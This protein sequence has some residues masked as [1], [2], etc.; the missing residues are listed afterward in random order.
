MVEL[1][2]DITKIDG[3]IG[4]IKYI[5]SLTLFGESLVVILTI[6]TFSIFRSRYDFSQSAMASLFIMSVVSVILYA[7]GIINWYFVGMYSILLAISVALAYK[8]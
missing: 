6:I 5:D 8:Q 3:I 7:I 1:L 4:F 2:Y